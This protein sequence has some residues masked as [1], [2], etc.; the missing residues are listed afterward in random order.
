MRFRSSKFAALGVLCLLAACGGSPSGA[1]PA[2]ELRAAAAEATALAGEGCTWLKVFDPTVANLALPDT[3]ANY[4]LAV[5]PNPG[6]LGTMHLRGRVPDARHFSFN[7]YDAAASP[8]DAIADYQIATLPAGANPFLAPAR[9]DRSIAPG[10]EYSLALSFEEIPEARP[11]NTLYSGQLA[12]VGGIA[13]PNPAMALLIYRT[14]VPVGDDTGGAGLPEIVLRSADGAE[15]RVGGG[16]TCSDLV[17]SLLTQA[18]LGALRELLEQNAFP[19]LPIGLPLLGL[20]AK[21]PPQFRL[22]YGTASLLENIGV[23]LPEIITAGSGFA[24]FFSTKNNRYAFTML[25]RKFG[26]MAIIRARAPRFVDGNVPGDP[27]LRYWSVCQS[28]FLTQRVVDCA[29]DYESPIDADGYFNV[30]IGDPSARPSSADPEHGFAWLPWG[31][32]YDGMVLVRHM[33]PDP[34]FAEAFHNVPQGTDPTSVSGEY[35]PRG[36]YCEPQVFEAAVQAGASP[37]DVFDACAGG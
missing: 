22:A 21:S 29:A 13:L 28:E 10:A 23:A 24:G 12:V 26:R 31:L 9:V 36:T 37:G 32:Y 16:D 34:G 30:V 7:S 17:H 27:Q 6:P 1:D 11:A 5:V 2:G 20:G 4:W 3:S 25:A 19:Q 35:F 14:Y 18:G 33:L 15:V 8:Y